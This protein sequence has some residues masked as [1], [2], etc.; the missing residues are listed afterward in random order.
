MQYEQ[1]QSGLYVP[2]TP[3]SSADA[4]REKCA[5]ILKELFGDESERELPEDWKPKNERELEQVRLQIGA[6]AGMALLDDHEILDLFR[7]HEPY[8]A[9]LKVVHHGKVAGVAQA[10]SKKRDGL[11][12]EKV[13]EYSERLQ[14]EAI[15]S[16]GHRRFPRMAEDDRFADNTEMI[17]GAFTFP[18]NDNAVVLPTSTLFTGMVLTEEMLD[19]VDSQDPFNKK[20]NGFH[21]ALASG[22]HG[23]KYE[24]AVDYVMRLPSEYF[25]LIMYY[26]RPR[27]FEQLMEIS[28]A[29]K[30]SGHEMFK[31]GGLTIGPVDSLAQVNPT[32][33]DT[34]LEKAQ[35][36]GSK[37]FG[38]FVFDK[39]RYAY[40]RIVDPDFNKYVCSGLAYESP[41]QFSETI[42]LL[43]SA[44]LG[45]VHISRDGNSLYHEKGD[46]LRNIGLVAESLK[47]EEVGD[48]IQLLKS[49]DLTN[50]IRNVKYGNLKILLDLVQPR[51][52]RELLDLVDQPKLQE[53]ARR[54]N[55]APLIELLEFLQFDQKALRKSAIRILSRG[56]SSDVE[57][58]CISILKALSEHT[59]DPNFH[60][61]EKRAFGSL[62]ESIL[63]DADYVGQNLS[64][65]R[66]LCMQKPLSS[67]EIAR[68]QELR[69]EV[70]GFITPVL[71]KRYI[72]LDQRSD[73]EEL[74]CDYRAKM[75][76][77]LGGSAIEGDDPD[78]VA[79]VTYLAYRP[80]GVSIAQI[81]EDLRSGR[82][83]DH[84][85]H[86]IGKTLRQEGYEF[87]F[88]KLE[89]SQTE[90][91]DVGALNA[92]ENRILR[93]PS[94]PPQELLRGIFSQKKGFSEYGD[95]MLAT[96]LR[97]L[98]DYRVT[99]Y[100]E[101]YKQGKTYSD[102]F[103]EE[104]LERLSELLRVIPAEPEFKEAV[105][106]LIAYSPE[107][108]DAARDAVEQDAWMK[109]KGT[110]SQE[111]RDAVNALHKIAKRFQ[112]DT[113]SVRS[114]M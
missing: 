5:E 101:E 73:R 66:T 104:R 36:R 45:D 103:A 20:I 29:F 62:V 85:D 35:V 8:L 80:I 38:E 71:G 48:L 18:E 90:E 87:G 27:S 67:K 105:G 53:N 7:K 68:L 50:S 59:S 111:V 70:R 106:T 44:I 40:M 33:L 39:G 16:G 81:T 107:A 102:V 31:K 4:A 93:K 61:E 21:Q 26:G 89:R 43:G 76:E 112:G 28:N 94:K 3:I 49:S 46:A 22:I 14:A 75:T 98:D 12:S 114:L 74:L 83:Q 92:V 100:Q 55:F 17:L 79:E 99:S 56:Y 1:R 9:F 24:G 69:G 86:L 51:S 60:T 23:G 6:R 110:A 97:S 109:R 113:D 96:V 41:Q 58:H 88:Q 64:A 82:V 52:A 54:T 15:V 2:R 65:L 42:S 84:T 91:F 63:I 10:L 19:R 13:A 30:A 57:K 77:V 108:F 78:L 11:V 95:M 47:I 37:E 32:L 25:R 34:L 72:A